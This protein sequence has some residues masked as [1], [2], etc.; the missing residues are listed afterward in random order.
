MTVSGFPH[1][2]NIIDSQNSFD[3]GVAEGM[4][5]MFMRGTASSS[6][7]N[8]GCRDESKCDEETTRLTSAV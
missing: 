4:L 1:T 6:A 5:A 2:I 7:L 8:N 3:S